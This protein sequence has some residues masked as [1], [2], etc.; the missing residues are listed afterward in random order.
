VVFAPSEGSLGA[1][2]GTHARYQNTLVRPPRV[3][4]GLLA[5]D[6][7]AGCGSHGAAVLHAYVTARDCSPNCSR[8]APD[9]P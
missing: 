1:H 9:S 4:G 6:I 5:L 8:K 2:H 3:V 7:A